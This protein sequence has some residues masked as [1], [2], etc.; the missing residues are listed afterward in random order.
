MTGGR[1]S[2]FDVSRYG[3]SVTASGLAFDTII[4]RTGAEVINPDQIGGG[5]NRLCS[6]SLF[7]KGEYGLRD[8]IFFTGEETGGGTEYALDVKRKKLYAVPALGRAAWENVTLIDA[9][10]GNQIAVLVGD[11]RQAAPL[12]L[13]VGDKTRGGFLERNGLAQGAL[14]VWVAESGET[15]PQQFNGTGSARHGTFVEIPYYQPDLAGTAGFDEQGYATQEKQD[16]LAAAAGAFQFSRPEDVATNPH[17]GRQVVLASTGRGGLFPADNWGTVYVIDVK[18][19]RR[20]KG[21]ISATLKVL[22]D[23]DDA[24]AGQFQGPDF[25]LRSPD[26]LDWSDNGLIYLQEDRSTSPGSLFGGTSGEEAS[27]WELNPYS[28]K[29]LRI[30]QVDRSAV[31]DGQSDPSPDDIGNWETSGIV[32][33]TS[34]FPSPRYE[35]LFIAVAQAHSLRDGIVASEGLAEGGQLM[36]VSGYFRKIR[37]ILGSEEEQIAETDSPNLQLVAE[38]PTE[39]SMAPAYPNPFSTTSTIEIDVPETTS[40]RVAVYDV[41]GRQVQLL[42]D[43]VVDAGR[44]TITLTSEELPAGQYFV[45]L[46]TSDKV[47]TRQVSVVK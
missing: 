27:V 9:G 25:G 24:G 7:D 45:R 26:N 19:P 40:I 33:V 35:T 11:D 28:G 6:A 13:Y 8:A 5:L 18:F 46:S 22:Y 36:F 42:K 2:Y 20:N 29:M 44:H 10:R 37:Y 38:I 1:V 14:Y 47:I 34:L 15:T 17:N 3:R 39:F 32:D 43:D 12:L 16:E 30:A 23:G 41:L 31:P 21:A 4:D